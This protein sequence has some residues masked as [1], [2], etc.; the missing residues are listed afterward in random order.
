MTSQPSERPWGRPRDALV[1]PRPT[2]DPWTREDYNNWRNRVWRSA[3]PAGSSPYSLR[4]GFVSL[5]VREGRYSVAEIAARL[6]HNQSQT[7]DTY[8]HVFDE[9]EGTER[10]PVADL[11]T[12][13]RAA[14]VS[15]KCP[16]EKPAA[17]ADLAEAA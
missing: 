17:E 2:G 9:F 14:Q 3:A 1:F 7:Q 16:D 10:V 15:E 4:H 5:L 6:G 8:S 13:A 11:I 12:A